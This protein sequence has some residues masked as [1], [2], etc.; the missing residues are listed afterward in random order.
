MWRTCTAEPTWSG[1][2]FTFSKDITLFKSLL[3][4]PQPLVVDIDNYI[5]GPYNGSFNATLSIEFYTKPSSPLLT[6]PNE[7]IP[8]YK[9]DSNGVS[10][11]FSLPDDNSS[12]PIFVPGGTSR[13]VLDVLASGN[14]NEEFWYSNLP[15]E[16]LDT[17]DRWNIS[18][19]G[20]GPF[21]EIV[22]YV[23]GVPIGAAWPFEVVFT[24][25]I[26]PGFWRPIVG[27]RTFNLPTYRIDMTHLLPYLRNGTHNI[28]FAVQ[29]QPTILENWFVS[30][31]E[32][33]P[34]M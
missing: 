7:V 31:H 34:K 30:G 14:G 17:F 20:G 4:S 28:E 24:G 32:V 12:T 18:F 10:T 23:D 33:T 13:L 5:V 15:N 3:Q 9:N 1:I 16:Y 29:G 2:H 6:L 8:L 21:R 11:Y 27:H 26:C 22:V 25:G 19:L